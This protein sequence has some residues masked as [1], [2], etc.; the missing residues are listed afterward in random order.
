MTDLSEVFGEDVAKAVRQ[1][2]AERRQERNKVTEEQLADICAIAVNENK[3]A[4]GEP[5]FQY[6]TDNNV[7]HTVLLMQVPELENGTVWEYLDEPWDGAA[8][9]P[10]DYL[11]DWM[12]C[13][14]PDKDDL[15][16]I[17]SGD[18]VVVV[19]SIDEY[20]KDNGEVIE[21][22]YPVRG[23]ATLDEVKEY[24]KKSM[25]DEGFDEADDE[26]ES[27]AEPDDEPDDEP[28]T[29]QDQVD[30]VPKDDTSSSMNQPG[31]L[32][33]DSD[34]IGK[35]DDEQDPVPYDDIAN[36][37]EQLAE[38]EEAVWDVGEGDDRLDKL[39]MVVTNKLDLDDSD[40]TAE[41]ILDVINEHNNQEEDD[42][43]DLTE[44]LFD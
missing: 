31:W 23:I 18:S 41:V 2:T 26:E 24:A 15:K 19:G 14:F 43:E 5:Q 6:T 33:S 9:L 32:D 40:A 22:V 38:N 25:S 4:E 39:T 44:S 20:E 16:K 13:T 10:L 12:R 30:D 42:E 28:D 29:E 27:F 7:T 1:K 3:F 21:S 11:G 17:D 36:L 37:V 8:S 34:D 35:D